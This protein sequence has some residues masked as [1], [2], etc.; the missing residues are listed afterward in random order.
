[1]ADE[2]QVWRAWARKAPP[3]RLSDFLAD[4]DAGETELEIT[5]ESRRFI[6]ELRELDEEEDPET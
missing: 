4:F 5:R 1:M 2:T 3:N 6:V